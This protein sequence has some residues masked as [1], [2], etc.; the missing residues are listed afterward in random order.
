MY[1]FE[2]PG[3]RQITIEPD[4]WCEITN[5]LGEKVTFTSDFRDSHLLLYFDGLGE[6][7]AEAQTVKTPR[8]DGERFIENRLLPRSI[9]IIIQ[10]KREYLS[11]ISDLRRE[12]SRVVN[13]RLGPFTIKYTEPNMDTYVIEVACDQSPTFSTGDAYGYHSQRSSL[14]FTA[15]DPY[16]RSETKVYEMKAFD[17]AFGFPFSFPIRFGYQG[18]IATIVNRGHEVSMPRIEIAGPVNIPTIENLSTGVKFTLDKEIKAG[19][20]L[21]ID[22]Q[23]RSIRIVS[24][25]DSINAAKYRKRGSGWIEVVQGDNDLQFTAVAGSSKGKATVFYYDRYVGI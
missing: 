17:E 16:W 1:K 19:E 15:Y 6:V 11:E 4:Q 20:T 10:L 8:M 13:P 21:V 7:G 25:T 23:N 3:S 2:M 14:N 18:Q 5:R 22:N 9:Q 24:Q 12:V